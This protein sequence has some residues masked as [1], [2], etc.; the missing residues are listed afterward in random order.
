MEASSTERLDGRG[1]T[2]FGEDLLCA[3][4]SCVVDKDD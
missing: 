4:V 1:L 3:L 2:P